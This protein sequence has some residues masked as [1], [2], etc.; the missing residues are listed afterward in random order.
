M[1]RSGDDRTV[2]RT[3]DRTDDLTD[4]LTDG[5]TTVGTPA[6]SCTGLTKSFGGRV[7]LDKVSFAIAPGECYGL[8]GPNGAGKTTTISIACG[9]LRPDAGVVNVCGEPITDGRGS[10]MAARGNIGYVPQD[11]A[12]YPELSA[13][14]NLKFFGRL[15]GLG[16]RHL[17]ARVT[18][19]VETVG[20]SDRANDKV[21]TY[22]GGMKR[23]ANIAA[24]LLHEPRVLILDEPT[25]GV[26]PQSR[27]AI[28]EMVDRRRSEGLA[29]L[30]TTHYMEE[31]ARVCQRIGIIDA[32]KLVVEDTPRG[33]TSRLGGSDRIR[34]T[35]EGDLVALASACADLPGVGASVVVDGGVALTA[36]DGRQL[37]PLV[38]SVAAKAGVS[39]SSAEVIEPDLED[40]FLALTG[41]ELRD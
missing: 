25:V 26:D 4:D 16:G 30:Y 11:V 2:D 27:H 3:V 28:L 31:A 6:L 38:V 34:V 35:G 36:D 18:D 1:H 41:K 24:A 39:L 21:G 37:I 20:L 15:Y 19:A 22:S 13:V 33:L 29:V 14:E 23:R 5:R 40:V 10:S 8:L 32:G 12:L 17:A 9:L 7:A